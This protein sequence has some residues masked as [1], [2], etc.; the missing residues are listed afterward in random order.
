VSRLNKRNENVGDKNAIAATSPLH[1]LSEQQ[2]IFVAAIVKGDQPGLA[3]RKAGYKS[4]EVNGHTVLKSA[5]VQAA[6]KYSYA[7]YAAAAQMTRK[8][9]MDGLLEAINIAKIQ[10]DPGVMVA[11]W[12][13]IGKMCGFYAPEVRKID[14][15]VTTRRV[16][17]QLEVLSD[18]ELLKIVDESADVLEGVASEVLDYTD[19]PQ[20]AAGTAEFP[21]APLAEPPR[22]DPA[23]SATV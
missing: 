1:Y 5:K 23:A 12:R 9:V 7:K 17:D 6:I 14:I 16:V 2:A 19:A 3:A 20:P 13:E 21:L 18:E 22:P 4:P 15:S 10:A 11:G 8:K